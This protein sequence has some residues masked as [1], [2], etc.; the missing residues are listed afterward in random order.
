LFILILLISINIPYEVKADSS[1]IISNRK[2]NSVDIDGVY[3][4]DEWSDASIAHI[5]SG[6][7]VNFEYYLN[8]KNDEEWIYICIDVVGDLTQN[9]GDEGDIIFDTGHD[10]VLTHGGEDK[11]HCV[12]DGI[13]RH[14]V[15]NSTHSSWP[16]IHCTSPSGVPFTDHGRDENGTVA[17]IGFGSSPN[18][19]SSHRIYEYKIPM[20]FGDLDSYPGYNLGV[21]IYIWDVNAMSNSCW[22]PDSSVWSPSTWGDI[23]LDDCTIY[24]KGDY[25]TIEEAIDNA[26]D[27]DTIIIES[28]TYKEDMAY[29]EAIAIHKK[30]TIRGEQSDSTIIDA[31]DKNWGI[32]VYAE[33]VNISNITVFNATISGITPWKASIILNCISYSCGTNGIQLSGTNTYYTKSD[34]LIDNC[35]TYG[36]EKGIKVI[37]SNN[38]TIKSCATHDN[39]IGIEVSY[40]EGVIIEDCEIYSSEADG[41]S[42]STTSDIVI[43][44]CEFYENGDEGLYIGDSK[45][46]DVLD[47]VAYNNTGEGIYTWYGDHVNIE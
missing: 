14:F 16:Y 29:N 28:G 45:E 18:S 41:V 1:T 30:L 38:V 25:S 9:A 32:F 17:A 15:Y 40:S 37:D 47:C 36:N 7:E 33:D 31:S 13:N 42:L 39:D 35:T 24:V 27:G 5:T 20:V 34:V 4:L 44:N 46:V 11:I 43:W 23:N 6:T 2:S 19:G 10:E 26:V 12:G 21:M 8:V 22:P 3:S